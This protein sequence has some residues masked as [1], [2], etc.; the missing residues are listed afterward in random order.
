MIDASKLGAVLP[1]DLGAARAICHQAVQLVTRAARANLP[2]VADDS[3]S[4]LGW[5]PSRSAFLSQPI[6]GDGAAI[7]VGMTFDPLRLL[8]ERGGQTT[9]VLE[10]DGRSV[11]AASG[12]LD[13]QLEAIGLNTIAET[14]LP[15]DLPADVGAVST[16]DVNNHH[17]ALSVLSGWFSFAHETLS[18][19]AARH[20]EMAPGPSPVRCWP[21]HFDIATYVAL[22]RGD[23]ETSRGIGLGLSPGDES[24]DQPYF[25]I[26]PWPHLQAGALPELPEPG[27]W[28]T[29][30]FVGAIAT[31]EAI[32][33][34]SEAIDVSAYFDETFELGRALLFAENA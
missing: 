15:Y 33:A 28:H 23:G 16:F 8:V 27:Q 17:G 18:D 13:S 12:W 34:R 29:Q 24:Y 32:L 10:L 5:D 9:G 26:N 11:G 1:R 21:H 25:Y 30:G 22:E 19:F 7:H 31:G 4:N 2:A 20:S 3:H 6:P 14:A